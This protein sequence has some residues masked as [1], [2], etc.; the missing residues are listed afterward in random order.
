[1]N[2]HVNY[3]NKKCLVQPATSELLHF[4]KV[5]LEWHLGAVCHHHYVV[6]WR[7]Q[8]GMIKDYMRWDWTVTQFHFCNGCLQPLS[9]RVCVSALMHNVR[10]ELTDRT[11]WIQCGLGLWGGHPASSSS[12]WVKNWNQLMFN[13]SKRSLAWS[14]GASADW[15][16]AGVYLKVRERQ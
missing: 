9:S 8:V 7:T 4:H 1:M 5:C 11:S 3:D 16:M 13:F 15:K 2:I 14:E 10:K 6:Q 12:S